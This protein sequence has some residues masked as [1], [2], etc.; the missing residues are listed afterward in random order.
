MRRAAET[1]VAAK[2]KKHYVLHILS[3]RLHPQ[4]PSM[5]RTCAVLDCHL[6]PVRFYHIFFFFSHYLISSTI[7]GEK[8]TEHKR[9]AVT[10]SSETSLI[11][12]RIRRDII[13]NVPTSSCKVL[14]ILVRF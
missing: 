9:C 11:L 10:F 8:V 5:L 7:F 1:T 2:K 13:I 12:R 6:R 14:V 3:V 4:L